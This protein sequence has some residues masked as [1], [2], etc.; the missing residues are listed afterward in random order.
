[1]RRDPRIENI[2]GQSCGLQSAKKELPL[3]LGH[4]RREH[5]DTPHD[6]G[7]A[8]DTTSEF[9]LKISAFA[10][11]HSEQPIKSRS[12]RTTY[13]RPEFASGRV[14]C[15]QDPGSGKYHFQRDHPAKVEFF[16]KRPRFAQEF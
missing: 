1:F 4:A 13:K 3:P 10:D 2:R 8:C 5:P 9:L 11:A 7:H 12:K 15:V 6:S 14:L 16:V